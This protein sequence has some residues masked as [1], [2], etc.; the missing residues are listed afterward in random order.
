MRQEFVTILKDVLVILGGCAG[1]VFIY[2]TGGSW[3][4]LFGVVVA[5]FG[6]LSLYLDYK[7]ARPN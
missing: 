2:L 6:L 4:S 1:G 5:G 3:L 7:D